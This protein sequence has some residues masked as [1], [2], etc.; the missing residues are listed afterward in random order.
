L[1][2]GGRRGAATPRDQRPGGAFGGAA[3]LILTW[4]S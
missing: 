1:S 2:S 4:L 3:R